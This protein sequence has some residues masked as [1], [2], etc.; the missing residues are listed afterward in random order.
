MRL[1][2]RRLVEWKGNEKY[3]CIQFRKIATWYT[4][5]CGCPSSVQQRLV[6][7]REPRPVRGNRSR[8]SPMP[9]RRRAGAS[10]TLSKRRSRSRP[11]RFRTGDGSVL[12]VRIMS[13]VTFNLE[14]F[15]DTSA[16][17][18]RLRHQSSGSIRSTRTRSPRIGRSA[19]PARPRT[20]SSSPTSSRPAGFDG[21]IEATAEAG[22]DDEAIA[23][24]MTDKLVKSAQAVFEPVWTETRG[25]DGYVSASSSIR[26]S[27]TRPA[28][29]PSRSGRGSTSSSARSGR[30]GTRTA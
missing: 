12:F 1:H 22:Q 7:L 24:E 19:P 10:T 11:D 5:R 2:V 14:A 29:C 3:G 18:R 27:K 16:I 21:D 23:W 30:P 20:R 6:M 15:N 4:R 13:L 26:C 25:N 28:T 17:P 8:P 9:A